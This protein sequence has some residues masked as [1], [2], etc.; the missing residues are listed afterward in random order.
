MPELSGDRD[1]GDV[2]RERLALRASLRNYLQRVLAGIHEALD[3]SELDV[4]AP[5]A[6]EVS[7]DGCHKLVVYVYVSL[8]RVAGELRVQQTDILSLDLDNE[9]VVVSYLSVS[10]SFAIQ[11]FL[12]PPK[13]IAFISN[14]PVETG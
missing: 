1:A 14:A 7:V 5:A 2:E 10:G 8:A 12:K 6:G 9:R 13:S 3:L 11:G 4:V